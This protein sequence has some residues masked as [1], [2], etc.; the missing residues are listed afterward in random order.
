MPGAGILSPRGQVLEH[1]MPRF[2]RRISEGVFDVDDLKLRAALLA[3]WIG[4]ALNEADETDHPDGADTARVV[5]LGFSNGANI[6]GA[7][8][9]GHP[10]VLAGAVLLRAMVP[11][12]PD[13]PP[14]LD[15]VPV[16]ISA[17][18]ADPIVP[19]GQVERLASILRSGG[20]DVTV[21]WQDAGHGLVQA[22]L[23]AAASFLASHF[24]ES[25]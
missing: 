23:D 25:R 14:L 6:A 5:A 21:V 4:T 16:L 2:F 18:R 11:Y 1:G 24:V 22:D 19:V 12:E 13:V 8:L 9:L 15:G 17:G 3:A 10:G 20:A 7:V